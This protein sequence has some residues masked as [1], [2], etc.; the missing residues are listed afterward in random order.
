M[1]IIDAQ[2]QK[3]WDDFVTSHEEANFLQAWAWGEFHLS[4]NKKIVRRIVLDDKD[5]P[6]AAY[7]GEIET[8]KRGKYMAIAG[9]PIMDWSDKKIIRA[10]FKDIKEQGQANN[11]VFIRVRPQLEASKKAEKLFQDLGLQ[12]A[13]YYLSVELAGVLDLNQSED[14]IKKNAATRIRRALNKAKKEGVTVETSVDPKDIKKFYKIQLE[15][16]SRHN[17]YA[18]SEDFLE[19]QFAAFAK[20]GQVKLYIAKHNNKILAEN[21]MIFYGNEASYH[22][23]VSSEAGTKISSAPLLHFTAMEDARK[24]GIKRYNFWGITGVDETKHRFYGVSQFKRGFGVVEL[25]YLHAHDMVLKPLA[26]KLNWLVETLRSK[27]RH[28]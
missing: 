9:G 28:V 14:E 17:F 25:Q 6:V 8:A 3:Q 10:V 19:K 22:Y 26:Y 18:F 11:C 23:G 2:D 20:N 24:Q 5:K 12:P 7:V 1:K 21:F 13:P 4:R 27:V 16:A 15:T